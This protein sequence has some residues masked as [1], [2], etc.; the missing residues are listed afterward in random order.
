MN[1][2]FFYLECMYR[3]YIHW[4]GAS[5]VTSKLLLRTFPTLKKVTTIIFNGLIAKSLDQ[6][7]SRLAL[8]GW[9][10]GLMQKAVLLDT[11]RIVRKFLSLEPW[12][13]VA[14]ISP[15]T[16]GL[17]LFIFLN[18]FFYIIKYLKIYKSSIE[19]NKGNNNIHRLWPQMAIIVIITWPLTSK[20][21]K[22]VF[23]IT[24]RNY[25]KKK[26]VIFLYYSYDTIIPVSS[27]SNCFMSS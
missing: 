10:K 1:T 15:V 20:R 14:W 8:D 4:T 5:Y 3:I 18:V 9:V 24:N 23:N 13:P 25:N 16:G 6:H 11:A 26:I 19:I 22:Y 12:P 21:K 2:Y 17:L 7:L 27:C